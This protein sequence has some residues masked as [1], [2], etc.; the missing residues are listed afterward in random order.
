MKK[1]ISYSLYGKN[2]L[3]TFGAI[4]NA[5]QIV[6]IY[7]EWTARFY[8]GND[9]PIEILHDLE[10]N[11]AEI[12]SIHGP[13][14]N[15]SKF[16]RFYA[17]EDP[18]ISHVIM[19]DTDSRL[20]HREAAAVQEWLQS[21][22]PGHIMRDHPYHT[23]PIMAGMWGCTGKLFPH[24]KEKIET[25]SPINKYDQDQTFLLKYIYPE[26]IK[27]GCMI[28]DEW[29][30]YESNAKPFPTPRNNFEFVGEVILPD[31]RRDEAW[32]VIKK[33]TQNPWE[34][35]K[36]LYRKYKYK[37]ALMNIK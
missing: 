23:M 21:D 19:R 25:F 2:P 6:N 27:R 35:I 9:V 5:K 24:I 4:E 7:P 17:L 1:I 8:C 30:C 26:L 22:L 11:K 28:H 14:D 36:I 32:R 37:I 15:R 13:N 16:W 10:K 12:I 20:T 33:A 29:Y 31:G 3:Y 34:K 18:E